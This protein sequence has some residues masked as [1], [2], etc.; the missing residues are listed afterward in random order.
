MRRV[1][2]RNSSRLRIASTM[3]FW[4]CSLIVIDGNLAEVEKEN[5]KLRQ[6]MLRLILRPGMLRHSELMK[7]SL[8][9]RH[10]CKTHLLA[11]GDILVLSY[12]DI[13]HVASW[14]CDLHLGAVTAGGFDVF[15]MK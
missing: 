14:C 4:I 8:R 2:R 9:L 15:N 12:I 3:S 11:T 6:G 1:E 13:Q 7:T 5:Y 10:R